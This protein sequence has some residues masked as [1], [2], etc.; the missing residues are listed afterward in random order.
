MCDAARRAYICVI[1]R[2]PDKL[3]PQAQGLKS[4]AAS[5]PWVGCA[6][7]RVAHKRKSSG[8]PG[9]PGKYKIGSRIGKTEKSGK[10]GAKSRQSGKHMP[11]SREGKG[12]SGKSGTKTG[13]GKRYLRRSRRGSSSDPSMRTGLLCLAGDLSRNAGP[14]LISSS[15]TCCRS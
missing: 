14:L 15:S 6:M 13:T 5:S 7:P 10:K 11:G 8:K 9:K 2:F 12:K 1:L 4:L 3:Y